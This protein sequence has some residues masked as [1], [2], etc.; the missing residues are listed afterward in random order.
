MPSV[1]SAA[2][3]I[4]QSEINLGWAW[5]SPNNALTLNNS[6]A[7]CTLDKAEDSDNLRFKN[8]NF[9]SIPDD[10]TITGIVVE[11]WGKA[12]ATNSINIYAVTL[13]VNGSQFGSGASSATA[14]PTGAFTPSISVGSS[15]N[16]TAFGGTAPTVSQ[17]KSSTSGFDIQIENYSSTNGRIG[18]ID[19]ATM[20]I[21]YTEAAG[22][23]SGFHTCL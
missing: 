18:Y 17:M 15:T 23:T 14:F 4:S 11:V 22:S 21:Y 20:T 1:T 6:G 13:V 5:T 7:S 8:L 16:L 2:G 19:Y 9:A 10:A 3:T 12:S